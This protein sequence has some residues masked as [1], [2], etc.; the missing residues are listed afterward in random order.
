ML[1]TLVFMVVY[2]RGSKSASCKAELKLS[3]PHQVSVCNELWYILLYYLYVLSIIVN[4]W[5]LFIQ[6]D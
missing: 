6:E 4:T 3:L 1:G 5:K 2:Q